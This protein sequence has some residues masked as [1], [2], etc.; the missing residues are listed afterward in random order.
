M[1]RILNC[2]G[3]SGI[4]VFPLS[5]FIDIHHKHILDPRPGTEAQEPVFLLPWCSFF[6]ALLKSFFWLRVKKEYLALLVV[7]VAT[8][9]FWEPTVGGFLEYPHGFPSWSYT[10]TTKPAWTGGLRTSSSECYQ[11]LLIYLLDGP[12]ESVLKICSRRSGGCQ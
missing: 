8:G 1:P 7:H 11:E 2:S 9:L 10:E 12:F 3:G 4:G 5:I 6:T